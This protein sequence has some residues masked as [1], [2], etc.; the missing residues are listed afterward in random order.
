MAEAPA[1][2]A[3]PGLEEA[4]RARILDTLTP[5]GVTRPAGPPEGSVDLVVG[6]PAPAAW[7]A[8]LGLVETVRPGFLPVKVLKTLGRTFR[9]ES[10]K[11]VTNL[12]PRME[13]RGHG[14]GL[15]LTGRRAKVIDSVVLWEGDFC[16]PGEDSD[17]P[18][19]ALAVAGA[20]WIQFHLVPLGRRDV[21]GYRRTF[22]TT[23]WR[24]YAHFQV[25]GMHQELQE[26]AAAETEYAAALEADQRNTWALF[27]A[28]VVDMR[29]GHHSQALRRLHAVVSHVERR[30]RPIQA[31]A[32]DSACGFHQ[33]PFWYQAQYQLAAAS[34]HK[35]I[36]ALAKK[37]STEEAALNHYK[38]A[39]EHAVKLAQ[40][41]VC[42][43]SSIGPV[44]KSPAARTLETFLLRE[45]EGP[46]LV[47]LA[48]IAA[49]PPSEQRPTAGGKG[50]PSPGRSPDAKRSSAGSSGSRGSKRSKRADES[51]NAERARAWALI[52]AS[53]ADPENSTLAPGL[54]EA[55]IRY[56]GRDERLPD[57]R[58]F[59]NLAC[60]HSGRECLDE[61]VDCLRFALEVPALC[62]WAAEDPALKNV[63]EKCEEEL[64]K[65]CP[66]LGTSQSLSRVR[67]IG[68]FASALAKRSIKTHEQLLEKTATDKD[69]AA[70]MSATGVSAQ[71]VERW[72]GA[73][74]L[75]ALGASATIVNLLEAVGVWS[76][77]DLAREKPAELQRA[78]KDAARAESAE[79][80]PPSHAEVVDLVEK[81]RE[82]V[83]L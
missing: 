74:R 26:W 9:P 11:L 44:Y 16:A 32:G 73:A 68:A 51:N 18:H 29:R 59:Y 78:L 12:L 38:E 66:E 83:G 47:L 69:V 48:D 70:L 7:D 41:T 24:S 8:V 60:Y 20:A 81:A 49:Q 17:A 56:V 6:T 5:A 14:V 67:F 46:A 65:I 37:K 58:T 13:G 72:K 23:S 22:A 64:G 15:S 77:T 40:D 4:L 19:P 52:E 50:D 80:T 82:V 2:K 3:L 33:D 75:L 36:E 71:T 31:G 53:K 76:V 57:H 34:F 1:P 79:A 30:G 43:L 61:A 42:A 28:A 54:E 62:K 63:R 21:P 25:A 27:N 55:L 45:I 39:A 10:V 35:W